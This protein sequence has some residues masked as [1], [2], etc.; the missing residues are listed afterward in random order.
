MLLPSVWLVLVDLD[1]DTARDRLSFN[2]SGPLAL[3]VCAWFCSQLRLSMKQ[4]KQVFILLLGPV[5]GVAA[6]T[7]FSTVTSDITFTG[8]SNKLTSG[9]FGPNQVS[10]ILGLGVLLTLLCI[11]IGK[12]NFKFRA[13]MF[14]TMVLL[15]IQS[16]LTFSRGGL[17]NA[18]GG[19]AVAI[20]SLSW[21]ARA[22]MRIILLA[23]LL[24]FGGFFIILPRLDAFTDG[25]LATRF[26][27]TGTTGRDLLVRSDLQIW[28]DNPIFGVGPGLSTPLHAAF[29]QAFIAHTELSRLL[30]EHGSF[31][32]LALILLS[33]MA[34][35]CVSRTTSL[36]AKAVTLA[37]LAWSFIYMLNAAMRLAAP[38]FIFGICFAHLLPELR[39]RAGQANNILAQA[40]RWG[41]GTVGRTSPRS[42]SLTYHKDTGR[43]VSGNGVIKLPRAVNQQR[44]KNVPKPFSGGKRSKAH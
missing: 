3:M 30:S 26:T 37:L 34:I 18:G 5:V 36:E 19:A 15:A 24:G 27:D 39:T 29:T 6:I 2:L 1:L 38:A 35:Q 14:V 22:R 28:A 20:V 25:K 8:E 4:V 32:F 10:A 44:D 42:L 41:R 12:S 17:M 16:A 7:V 13:L 31:G 40:K 9:G 33:A 21:D 43:T 11:L 23:L